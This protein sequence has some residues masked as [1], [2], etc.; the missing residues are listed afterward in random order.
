[1]ET[2]LSLSQ[3]HGKFFL[4]NLKHMDAFLCLI[5]YEIIKKYK[6]P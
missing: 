4:V 6:P 2:V 1:M 5:D 3:V